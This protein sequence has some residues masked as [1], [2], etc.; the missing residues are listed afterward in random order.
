MAINT[1]AFI[2]DAV[3]KISP[4]GNSIVRADIY[5]RD[6]SAM[7]ALVRNDIFIVDGGVVV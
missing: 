6:V 5:P 3:K 2:L 7:V 4:L 1:R